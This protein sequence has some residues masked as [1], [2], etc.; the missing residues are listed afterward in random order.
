MAFWLQGNFYV[1]AIGPYSGTNQ[2]IL[3]FPQ[4]YF[5]NSWPA[6]Q[7]SPNALQSDNRFPH[8]RFLSAQFWTSNH[9]GRNLSILFRASQKPNLHKSILQFQYGTIIGKLQRYS[10]NLYLK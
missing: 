4:N 7:A 5:S 8:L 2:V 10:T 9:Y 1:S 6:P 3:W